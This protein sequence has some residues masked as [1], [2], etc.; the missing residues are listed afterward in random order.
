MLRIM[1]DKRFLLGIISTVCPSHEI[2]SRDYVYKTE[3]REPIL[4]EDRTGFFQNLP[5]LKKKIRKNV[6]R[7]MESPKAKLTR[8]LA[9]LNRQMQLNA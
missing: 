1:P 8:K 2:F 6:A 3:E 4:I 5:K 7:F 9:E